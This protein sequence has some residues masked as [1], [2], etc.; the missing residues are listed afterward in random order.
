MCNVIFSIFIF[1][2]FVFQK[3]KRRAVDVVRIDKAHSISR[4]ASRGRLCFSVFESH[5]PEGVLCVCVCRGE[6][7]ACVREE[8]KGAVPLI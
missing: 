6:G 3:K 8:R 2:L 1:C 4:V 5:A 7:R